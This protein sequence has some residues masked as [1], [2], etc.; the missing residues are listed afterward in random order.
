VRRIR[1]ALAADDLDAT[2]HDHTNRLGTCVDRRR[3]WAV[4]TM[5][6]P[7]VLV[8]PADRRAVEAHAAGCPDL[9]GD[10]RVR[11]LDRPTQRPD[12]HRRWSER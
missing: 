9:G 1:I 5:A 6:N 12:N 10:R 2:I 7:V 3:S 4:R 8:D 11:Q